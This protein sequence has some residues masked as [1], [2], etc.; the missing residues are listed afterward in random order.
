MLLPSVNLKEYT[1]QLPEDRIAMFPL[2][3]R[4]QSK[5]LLY[6]DGQIHHKSFSQLPELLPFNSILFFNDTKVIPARFLFEKP[7]GGTIEIFLLSPC[8]AGRW[9]SSALSD[10]GKTT[11]AC[12]IGNLKRWPE[13]LTLKKKFT[14]LTLSAN[15]VDRHE[16]HVEFSWT[17]ADMMFGEV[18]DN[19]GAIPLPPYIKR[20]VEAE[21]RERYQTV[22]SRMPGAVAAPT[23]GL[24]F[25]S[26]T[27]NAIRERKILTDFLSLHVGAGTFLPVKAENAL[28]HRMHT[29]QIIINRHNLEL[30]LIPGQK[31]IAVGTTS[32]RTLESV[33][34]LGVHLLRD[35]NAKFV[36]ESLEP[37]QTT[38]ALPS[39]RDAVKAVIETMDKLGIDEW[40]GQTSI[41]ILPGYTFHVCDGLVTN[42]HQPGSTLLLLI[43]AF[44]G[45]DWRRI[46][47]EALAQG[48]RFLSYGDSSLLLRT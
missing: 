36:I 27:M 1:Y 25:T 38:T 42:F 24:H 47:D 26:D 41:Y 4:D 6:N 18:I 45:S 48:Y 28:D 23:A 46:Y 17:P 8:P 3:Q 5:L 33:Y 15:L 2:P 39:T 30:L 10:P 14:E 29:E 40:P 22:Y 7:S 13:G 34:W 35:P 32:L 19:A 37:Y 44:V 12:T 20:P 9:A 21:D 43:A 31:V 16:G 11:W